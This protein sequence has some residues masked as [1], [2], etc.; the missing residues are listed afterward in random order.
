MKTREKF[1]KYLPEETTLTN[2]VDILEM[3][4]VTGMRML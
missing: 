2:P 3:L 4:R 1:L